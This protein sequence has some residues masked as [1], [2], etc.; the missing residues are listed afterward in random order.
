MRWRMALVAALAWVATTTTASADPLSVAILSALGY[1]G[2]AG[3]LAPTA[4]LLSLVG[5]SIIAA[6][7]SI[8]LNVGLA[9]GASLLSSMLSPKPNDTAPSER[10]QTV[11]QSTGPRRKFYGRNL[12][13][14]QLSFF[15]THVGALYSQVIHNH[16]EIGGVVQYWLGDKPVTVGVDG[17][18]DD[19]QYNNAE[20]GFNLVSI[21]AKAGT[22]DEVAYSD[23][24]A[25][26]AGTY[27]TDHR[28]R[29][30]FTTLTAYREVASDQIA[31]VYPQNAPALRVL[32]DMSKVRRVRQGDFAYSD[33][34]ADCIYDY[35][36]DAD[37]AGK[38]A[39]MVDLASFQDFANLCDEPVPKKGG[40]T[41]KRYVIA[42]NYALN[43]QHRTVLD[44]LLSCCDAETY[45]TPEGKIAI[46]GGKWIEPTVTLDADQGHILDA[47][48][49]QGNGELAA[50]NR[51]A[52]IYTEPALE[53]T[54][55]EGQSWVDVANVQL[56]GKY[57]NSQADLTSIP[58]HAQ[59]RRVGKILTHKA[60][61][62]WTGTLTTNFYG[63]NLI[64]E[65]TVRVL[66]PELGIATTF[67]IQ[68]LEFL[69]DFTGVRVTVGSLT[70]AAYSWDAE[71]EEGAG[72]TEPADTSSP[73]DLSAPSDLTPVA[74]ER[75]LSGSEVGVYIRLTWTPLARP[76]LL[77]E[78]QYRLSPS[79]GWLNMSVA[80]GEAAAESGLVDEGET[81]D[82][83]ARTV[84]PAGAAGPWWEITGFVAT[85]AP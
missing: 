39:T 47:Q 66:F 11:R 27:T 77:V 84:S 62:L 53:Y 49:R 73:P 9:I 3:L 81:Y 51:L 58:V 12:V 33:N 24:L 46:R 52:I 55:Q 22:P 79:G 34:P 50:F 45:I 64:G 25:A 67:A 56:R 36:V 4:V 57:L 18:V 20:A 75:A 48:W 19:A 42:T 80:S 26:F 43:E 14:G 85:P 5:S 17:Y 60:N 63:F 59:A 54:E 29:G 68:K 65:T 28:L 71:L 70:S 44:R 10:Q 15:E 78:A 72:P 23:L 8:L 40:G 13:G 69:P 30:L 74:L 21:K 38:P 41:I 37:G 61:P 83:R 82:I 16:G 6:L 31:N 1:S 76:A 35:L 32:G 7:P 2:A